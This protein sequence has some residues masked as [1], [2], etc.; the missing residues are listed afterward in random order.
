MFVSK[1]LGRILAVVCALVLSAGSMLAQNITV[2]GKVVDKGNEPIIGAYVVVVGTTVGTSTDANGAYRI[3]VPANGTLKFTC[4]GYKDQEVAV[5][6][7][8]VV[9]VIMAD[10]AELLQETVVTALGIKK[11]RKALGY[12]V[13]EVKS[14][15]LLRN[16]QTNV[17]NSLAGK[18]PGVNVTQAGGAAGAGSSIIIRGG[19]SASE[20]RDNQPLFVVDGIIY[21][22]ST[23]NGGNSGTDGVTKT[24]TTFSNR[25]MD[26]NPEDIETMSVLKGAA[27]AALYGSRAA[28]GVVVI[29]TKKGATDGHVKVN[30]SSKYS[31]ATISGAPEIQ[32]T[33]ARGS[34]DANGMLQTDQ[35][36]SSWGEKLKGRSYDNVRDFFKGG[37]VFDNSISV[38]GGHKNG[39]FF[40]SASNFTQGG[41]VPGTSYVKNTVRFNGEQKYGILTV[42]ANVAYSIADTK[43][44]LT[45]SG[46]Y[47]GGGNGTMTALYMWPRSE[48]MSHWLNDDGTKYRMFP[49][50]DPSE[51]IENPYWII[52]R[53]VLT[54][55]NKRI[56]GAVTANL[57][58]TSWLNV[59]YRMGIDSYNNNGYTYIAPGGNVKSIYQNGRLSKSDVSYDYWTSNLMAN[60]HKTFGDFDFNLLLGTTAE[61]TTRVNNTRWGWDFVTAGTISF[62]NIID[63]NKKFTERTTRKRLVGVYGEF[64]AAYKNIAY[65]TVTGRNDWSSTLPKANNSYFYPS[66]SGSFVFTELMPKNNILTFGKLRASW[67]RVGKDAGPYATNTYLWDAQVVNG[68]FVGIGNSW[69]G[70]SP[71]LVPEIQTSWEVGTELKFFGGRLGID[72]T[73]YNSITRNQIA[74]PRLAQ[75]TGYIFLTINSGS[76]Q[77]KGME[78]MITGTP[79]ETRD[80][81]WDVTL[82]LSGNRGTLGDF[83]DGVDFF[84]VT[85]V[86]IGGVKAASIPNGGY[87]LG[88][89]GNYWLR[90]TEAVKEGDVTKQVEKPNGRYEIDPKTGLYKLKGSTTNVVGNREPIM[91]GGLNNNFRWK[92]LSLSFL[93][94]LRLG[95]DMYNGTQYF[96]TSYGQSMRTLNRDKITFSGVV[97][98][99]TAAEPVWEEKT[100]TYEAG[101][102]YIINGREYS[103]AN[104]IQQYYSNYCDNAYNFIEKVNWLRLRALNLSYD[105]TSLIKGQNFIKGL[106]ATASA[107]N[108]FV[109][110]NYTGG[111]DPEAAATGSGTGGSGSVGIEYCGVPSQRTFSFGVNLTF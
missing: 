53:N 58:L 107:N 47:D 90:E 109:W 8:S 66:V 60:A 4:I 62:G 49:N 99:G 52:N 64:R 78:L 70:G 11:E 14:E 29:T 48:N 31:Y 25:V 111:L 16:K 42:G 5:S 34:Y 54:D 85:D 51:E 96:L 80:F 13:T 20:G 79:V 2:T 9:D 82:N 36:M 91:I 17:I 30:F 88:L 84:Y 65:L 71:Y 100:I 72:Y 23:I 55:K 1:K 106:T 6:G 93:L 75:S 86:Q 105:F 39:S 56:T 35:V 95:G 7:R 41:V 89:T 27:A 87:F 12:S 45:T 50:V 110:T 28:D 77:N 94:D 46:L 68:N 24:A 108:L 98:N 102:T 26:I 59:S 73:Y 32:N 38:S 67:A 37:N 40:L 92:N 43:K 97:N 21:D 44:T 104:M 63:E 33:Y 15:E 69:T 19:N 22:N 81:S 74:A 57:D 103:G 83:V 18:V 3:N 61:S 76:V 10:D 101:Q